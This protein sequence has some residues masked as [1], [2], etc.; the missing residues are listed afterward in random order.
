MN[1]SALDQHEHGK[2]KALGLCGA[3]AEDL[4]KI[5]ALRATKLQAQ[6]D[7]GQECH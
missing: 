7:K 2:A 6:I 5:G 1:D 3:H 4:A